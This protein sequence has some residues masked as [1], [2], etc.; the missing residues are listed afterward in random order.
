MLPK[1]NFASKRSQE[2]G[3][4]TALGFDRESGVREEEGIKVNQ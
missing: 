3:L 4:F 1:K 2:E